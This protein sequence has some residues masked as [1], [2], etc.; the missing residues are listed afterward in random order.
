MSKTYFFARFLTLCVSLSLITALSWSTPLEAKTTRQSSQTVVKKI[1]RKPVR[2]RVTSRAPDKTIKNTT[3]R[4]LTP[5]IRA[6]HSQAQKQ[7]QSDIAKYGPGHEKAVQVYTSKLATTWSA[8]SEPYCGIGSRGV[9]AVKK[10]FIKSI[11][12]IR[13]EFLKAVK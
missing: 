7:M 3:S 1:K 4:C 12:H 10:S 11:S 13:A 5:S 2:K 8:M 9:A 6:L